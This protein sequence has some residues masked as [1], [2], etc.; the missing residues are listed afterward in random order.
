MP[1]NKFALIRYRVIDRLISNKYK[2]YP[3]MFDIIDACEDALGKRVSLSTIE[4]DINAMKFDTQLGFLAPIAFSKEHQGYFYEDA[5]YSINEVPLSDEEVN[6][7][8]LAAQTIGQFKDVAIFKHYGAAI[9][10][11]LNKLSFDSSASENADAFI[12]F[13]YQ[14]TVRGNTLLPEILEAIKKRKSLSFDYESFKEGARGNKRVHPYLLKEY[15]N[16]WYLI[17]FDTERKA[18]RTYGLERMDK[19][20]VHPESFETHPHFDPELFFKHSL[21]ITANMAA[22]PEKVLFVANAVLAKYLESQPL[23]TSQKVKHIS[24]NA[25]EV[26]LHVF[27]SYELIEK[28]LSFGTQAKVI[29]PKSFKNAIEKELEA[30]F[31]QY[32]KA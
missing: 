20:C 13:E 23:H 8:R 14:P 18:L 11:I 27:V 1:A 12:Q 10:K 7:I 21:G 32:K 25:F 15:G 17:A 19:L 5:D 16:R 4:K 22:K 26:Q 24:D 31:L 30:S 3:N 29:S 28:V 6:A 9:D 2:P